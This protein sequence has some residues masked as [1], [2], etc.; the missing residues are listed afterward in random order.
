[1]YT[2]QMYRVFIEWLTMQTILEE[3]EKQYAKVSYEYYK[4]G[5]GRR[6]IYIYENIW[7]K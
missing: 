1:M 7:F 3:E 2:Q 4:L 6:Y 5:Q